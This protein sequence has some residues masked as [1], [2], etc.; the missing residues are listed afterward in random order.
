L[1]VGN[2]DTFKEMMRVLRTVES[3]YSILPPTLEKVE[4]KLE[5]EEKEQEEELKVNEKYAAEIQKHQMNIEA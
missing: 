5:R 2:E 3:K 4:M 1:A